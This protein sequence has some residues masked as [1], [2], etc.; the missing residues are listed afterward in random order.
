VVAHGAACEREPIRATLS[1]RGENGEARLPSGVVKS[2]PTDPF[3]APISSSFAENGSYETSTATV[4]TQM[5]AKLRELGKAGGAPVIFTQNT[6]NEKT[7]A[8]GKSAAGVSWKN[9]GA[10]V[11]MNSPSIALAHELGHY[12]GYTNNGSVHAPDNDLDN[13]MH[14][15]A[16][17]ANADKIYL[18]SLKGAA[19]HP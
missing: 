10:Y 11:R 16:I 9:I 6:I 18:N 12:W 4:S 2:Q 3:P 17:K 7:T 13:L 19:G 5:K 1:E 14:K 8:S 15:T